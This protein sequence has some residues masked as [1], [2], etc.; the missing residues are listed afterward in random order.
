MDVQM[1][2][3]DGYETARL[4]R[5]RRKSEHIPIIFLTAHD[6]DSLAVKRAYDLGAVDFLPKPLDV[7]VLRA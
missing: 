1:P 2:D 3:M 4:I 7:D 6:H 5:A